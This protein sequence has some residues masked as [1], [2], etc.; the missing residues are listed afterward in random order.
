VGQAIAEMIAQTGGKNLSF[1]LHAAECPAVNNAIAITL[2][3]VA[4]G[5]ARFRIAPTARMLCVQ[6]Q[7]T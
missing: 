7:S 6:A 2:K 4:V 3:I 1:P 5:M